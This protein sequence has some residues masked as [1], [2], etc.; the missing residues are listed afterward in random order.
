MINPANIWRDA[1]KL[2][3]VVLAGVLGLGLATAAAFALN[4]ASTA[5]AGGPWYVSPSGDNSDCLSWATACTTIDGALNKAGSGDTIHVG[6]GTYVENPYISKDITLL[7]AGAGSTIID[8]NDAGSTLRVY[9]YISV[10]I[11]GMTLRNGANVAGGGL[12]AERNT[13]VHVIDT[14]IFDNQADSG[15]GI[16]MGMYSAVT[17]TNSAVISNSAD[18]YGGGIYSDDPQGALTIIDSTVGDNVAGSG[19]GGVYQIDGTLTIAGSDIVS[20][21]SQG[22]GGGIRKASGTMHIE[23]TVIGA[24]TAVD[25]GGGIY[26]NSAATTIED[27]TVR[28]NQLSG[29]GSR[30]GGIFNDAQMALTNVT[31]SG[32]TSLEYGGGIH[33]QDPMTLT[34]VTVS[35]NRSGGGS[36]ILH[37]GSAVTMHLLNCTVYSNTATGAGNAFGILLYGSMTARNTIIADNAGANCGIGGGGSMTSLGYNLESADTCGLDATG[38]ITDTASLLGPLQDN[39]GTMVGLGEA[40]LTHALLPRSPAINAG[41][42]DTSSLPRYDQRGVGFPRVLYSRVDIGAYE[43]TVLLDQHIYLPLAVKE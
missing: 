37:T 36:G 25:Y 28:D 35:G 3:K 8:G 14:T 38:D 43:V 19:G 30:G 17:L 29:V 5:Q 27:S 15:G 11:S 10:T 26:G 22:D 2:K 6:T 42:P 39:G 1:M 12:Q 32:N 41:D 40:T 18:T 21:T 13:N 9:Q 31:V 33:S 20:N 4:P 34:N 24:N 23:R 16:Y 7:G